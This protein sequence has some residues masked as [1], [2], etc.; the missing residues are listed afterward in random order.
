MLLKQKLDNVT[1]CK[2][3]IPVL[4]IPGYYS[5]LTIHFNIIQY[6]IL[7]EVLEASKMISGLLKNLLLTNHHLIAE[8]HCVN[9]DTKEIR[10][11]YHQLIGL[12]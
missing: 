11:A 10:M 9:K 6:S 3:L 7:L 4:L 2:V 8:V 1:I 12:Q 5:K